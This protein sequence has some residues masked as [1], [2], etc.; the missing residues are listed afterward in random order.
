MLRWLSTTTLFLLIWGVFSACSSSIFS[1]GSSTNVYHEDLSR[2]RIKYDYSEDAIVI[3]ESPKAVK[4]EEKVVVSTPAVKTTS[5]EKELNQALQTINQQN[6]AVRFMPGFRIQIYVGNI[7]AEADAA[8]AFVYRNF[9]E[10][11]PYVTFSQP[12]YRVK[13]GDFMNKADAEHILS[14]VKAQYPT[15]VIIADKIEIEK[16]LLQAIA[17]R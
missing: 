10:M 7:R 6:K 9:P 13:I 1:R 2:Y 3:K 5:V 8:K 16:G 11:S 4:A 14:S 15:S 17:D 12:T